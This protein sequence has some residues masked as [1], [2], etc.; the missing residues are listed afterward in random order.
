MVDITSPI[1]G[2]VKDGFSVQHDIDYSSETATV[3]SVWDNFTDPESGIADYKVHVH[4][5]HA[6]E[7]STNVK[8]SQVYEDHSFTMKHLDRVDVVVTATN[9]AELTVDVTS[10]GFLVDLTPPVVQFVRDSYEETGFQSTDT[11]LQLSW[12][13]SDSESHIS[14]YRLSVSQ[15]KNGYKHRIWPTDDTYKTFYPK[16]ELAERFNVS[17]GLEN[18]GK[19]IAH[20]TALNRAGLA[21]S[22]D[23]TGVVI[24]TTPPKVLQV[25]TCICASERKQYW[26]TNS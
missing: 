6:L 22:C 12:L 4:I 16:G 24:D 23:S 13:F 14:Q 8:L 5:N 9:G 19:Y 11:S 26:K 18:G 2:V 20:V 10:D 1:P 25:S 3:R 17:L 7:K 15:F 21:S